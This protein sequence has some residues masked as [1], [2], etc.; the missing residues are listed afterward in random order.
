MFLKHYKTTEMT[1]QDSIGQ[2]LTGILRFDFIIAL[3]VAEHVLSST[4]ALTNLLQK[5]D[6]NLLHAIGETKVVIQLMSETTP[7][8]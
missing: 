4:V 6:N 1:K 3:I 7:T 8:L 5:E 2:Y